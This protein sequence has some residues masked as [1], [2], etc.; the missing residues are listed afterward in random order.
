MLM[1]SSMGKQLKQNIRGKFS[2][3]ISWEYATNEWL[4]H[5]THSALINEIFNLEKLAYD[6]DL[7]ISFD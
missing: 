4:I 2:H 6:Y 1:H 5:M 7:R 3:F